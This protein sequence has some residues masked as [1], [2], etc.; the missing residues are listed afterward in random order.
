[1][2]LTDLNEIVKNV[3]KTL[4]CPKCQHGFAEHSVDVV[5][6]IGNKGVFA[7]TCTHCNT[8]T[9]VV[10]GVREF[11]QKIE[12]RDKQVSKVLSNRVNPS[13]VIDMKGFLD[14]FNGD[15]RMQLAEPKAENGTPKKV[16]KGADQTPPPA[17]P[18][19][20]GV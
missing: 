19:S 2:R 5:D 12:R 18:A 14:A 8:S 10:M 20:A 13:D 11:K 15:F 1:M 3:Q 17:P 16:E 4:T 7:A 6:I 9:M